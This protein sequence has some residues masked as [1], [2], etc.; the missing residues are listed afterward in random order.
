MY[1]TNKNAYLCTVNKI[2]NHLKLIIVMERKEIISAIEKN[3]SKCNG[4]CF[5]EDLWINNS[6]N[7]EG[8]DFEV[9]HVEANRI[10]LTDDYYTFDELTDD[11]L[12]RVLDAV[13]A[14]TTDCSET[15]TQDL[16]TMV[17]NE[18]DVETVLENAE[19]Y[20]SKDKI[21]EFLMACLG[22]SV[23]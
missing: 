11:E 5:T 22:K 18:C 8:E 1:I 7:F 14:V 4:M 19:S 15:T 12:E 6:N 13:L 17:C 3:V 16:F 2:Y 21:R 10:V 9:N 23:E 20:I